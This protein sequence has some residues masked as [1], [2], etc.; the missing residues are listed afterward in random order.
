MKNKRQIFK[1]SIL[2]SAFLL[3]FCTG[4]FAAINW[5]G[6]YGNPPPFTANQTITDNVVLWGNVT[7][8]ITPGFF[9]N[10]SGVISAN[11]NNTYTFTKA[12]KGQLR[13]SGAN[14]YPGQTIINAGTLAIGDIN[15]SGSVAGNI[16]VKS[17][18]SLAFYSPY[19]Y[20]YSKVISG[21][22]DVWKWG[23][24]T[25]LTGAN[26]Y[27]G[28]TN[29]QE[30]TLQIGNGTSGSIGAT[31]YVGIASG[32]TLRFE[33][34]AD[35]TFDKIISGA[36]KVEYEG[37]PS[38]SL[39]FTANNYYM[40][41]TT[42]EGGGHLYIGNNTQTGRVTG[43]IEVKNE[44][45]VFFSRSN[46]YTYSKVISGAGHVAIDGSGK[47]ILTG[48]NIYSGTT[49][50]NGTLQIGNGTSGSI[51]NT[52]IVQLINANAILR[53]EP[54]DAGMIFSKEISGAG[55]VEYKGSTTKTLRFTVNNT[56]AGTTTIEAG[57]FYIGNGGTEGAVVGN[58]YNNGTLR[59][60]RS[61]SYTYSGVIAG[62]GDVEQIGKTPSSIVTL[63]GENTYTGETHI[64]APLVLSATG[65][66]ENSSLVELR[67]NLSTHIAKFDISAG[68]KKIKAL[69]DNR[70]FGEV[71]LGSK[72]LTIGTDGQNDGRGRFNAKFT[73]TGGVIKT[74]NETFIMSG[75]NTTTGLFSIK[76]GN[77]EFSNKWAGDF[78]I[79]ANATLD[80]KGAVSIGKTFNMSGGNIYMN[81]TEAT[82]SKITVADA[83]STA[84]KNTL[85]I[86]SGE[87]TNHIIIQAASGLNSIDPYTL[88]MPGYTATLTATGTSLLL[89]ATITDATPPIPGTGIFGTATDQTAELNWTAATD[90][91]TPKE[92]L[93]Y[94][95]YQSSSNDI[96]TAANCETNGT[97]LNA[98]GSIDIIEYSVSGLT[99]KTTYY[100]NVVVADM[101]NNKAAYILKELTTDE[102]GIEEL[103]VTSYE[104]QVYPN[105][106][107]GELR[108]TSDKLQVTSIEVF[109]VMGRKLSQTLNST[110]LPPAGGGDL[111][112]YSLP[113]L[114]VASTLRLDISNFPA[115]IYLLRIQ[116]ENGTVMKKVIKSEL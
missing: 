91:V 33:P 94:F 43:D 4:A 14:T 99:P 50:V 70:G 72:T 64:Y 49:L 13:L 113:T 59:F 19:L 15:Q 74:G 57:D 73:G 28:S 44:A 109:D 12:G 112:H 55:K 108:V 60:Y 26:T 27:T 111:S 65:S 32:A 100:F 67:E 78:N 61:N 69:F 76:Q 56:Y 106:T 107:T 40:G 11:G 92:N 39:R 2:M 47:I 101:A 31:S 45:I 63:E 86:A 84:G 116:T 5:G 6:T 54:G 97:L 17:D 96:T 98:G 42:V 83:V 3:M 46:E 37:T 38:Q 68:D 93:R 77:V 95:V 20:T 79:A 48:T 34:G 89:T 81:L 105:P 9:V 23:G 30:G 41:T 16:E 102:V 51:A 7:V 88:N 25:I 82:P 58:I 18:A 1:K 10:I 87:V 90:N 104:L 36:G 103:Q 22:G 29:V 66:I 115:G 8:T 24:R 110:P 35:M 85:H 71:A 53:F 62:P 80:V 52:A 75:P 21:E 114:G